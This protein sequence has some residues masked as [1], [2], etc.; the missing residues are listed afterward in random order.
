MFG[1]KTSTRRT[2]GFPVLG[3]LVRALV[4]AV[5]CGVYLSAALMGRG[6]TTGA[7]PQF[8]GTHVNFCTHKGATS[9]IQRDNVSNHSDG[10]G[11]H[12][13]CPSGNH[14]HH[15]SCGSFAGFACL[16]PEN[17]SFVVPGKH[18]GDTWI[19]FVFPPDGPFFELEKPPLI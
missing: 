13:H 8:T 10:D 11:N 9:E 14:C 5:I 3:M 19:K 18:L 1:H 4:V 12:Q 17:V 2:E 16:L 6:A 7:G 15:D